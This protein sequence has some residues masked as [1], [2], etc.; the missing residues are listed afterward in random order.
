[1][2]LAE[3]LQGAEVRGG[4]LV[5]GDHTVMAFCRHENSGPNKFVILDVDDRKLVCEPSAAKWLPG[6][7]ASH[8]TRLSKTIADKAVPSVQMNKEAS[9]VNSSKRINR[10]R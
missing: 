8:L 10:K 1:M 4:V 2:S 5:S 9:P 3:L 7:A 6:A